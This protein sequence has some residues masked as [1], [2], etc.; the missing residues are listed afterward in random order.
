MLRFAALVLACSA[1]LYAAAPKPFKLRQFHNVTMGESTAL[2]PFEC[3][4]RRVICEGNV[5]GFWVR[6]NAGTEGHVVLL[7]VIYDGQT[8]SGEWI[9]GKV[10]DLT[11]AL[12][13]HSYA[14]SHEAFVLGVME[15]DQGRIT[16]W[17]DLTNGIVYQQHPDNPEKGIV[18]VT[19]VESDAPILKRAKRTAAIDKLAHDTYVFLDSGVK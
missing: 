16:S 10:P 3:G 11:D 18:R 14:N 5:D 12:R 2:L 6:I 4:A 13:D 8:L 1:A 19:Y 7:D 17:V 9:K 15:D